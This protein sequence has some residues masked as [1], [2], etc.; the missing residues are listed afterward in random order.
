[1]ADNVVFN[2]SATNRYRGTDQSGQCGRLGNG[3]TTD[4]QKRSDAPKKQACSSLCQSGERSARSKAAGTCHA[5]SVTAI[6]IQQLSGCVIAFPTQRSDGQT[7][8]GPTPSRANFLG[9][10]RSNGRSGEPSSISGGATDMSNKCCTIWAES[11]RPEKASSGEAIASQK[12][13]SPLVK[14]KA[15]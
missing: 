3:R 9:S 13:A 15:R 7:K 1:M 14:A 5:Q 8:K 12:V 4:H 6:T 2:K 11:S 10:P